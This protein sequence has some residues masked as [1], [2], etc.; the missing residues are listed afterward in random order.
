MDF[1]V[2]N[3][4]PST[5]EQLCRGLEPVPIIKMKA[6]EHADAMKYPIHAVLCMQ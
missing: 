1:V 6:S 3:V 5:A 2:S 4:T